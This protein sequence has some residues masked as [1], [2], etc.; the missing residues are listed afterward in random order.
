MATINQLR[1]ERLA[2]FRELKRALRTVDTEVE[3]AERK[4]ESVLNRKRDVPET[5]DFEQITQTV[6]ELGKT[7][8]ALDNVLSLGAALFGIIN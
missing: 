2:Y 8:I 5:V 3:K 1:T 4:I 6:E 7:L